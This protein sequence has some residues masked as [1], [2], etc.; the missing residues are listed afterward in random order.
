MR[1]LKRASGAAV[2]ALV[3]GAGFTGAVLV[4]PVGAD[5]RCNRNNHSHVHWG[6]AHRDYDDFKSVTSFRQGG[7]WYNSY[8]HYRRTHSQWQSP[9]VCG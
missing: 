5:S 7:I 3:L 9:A 4:D 8:Q 1:S 2:A 6:N